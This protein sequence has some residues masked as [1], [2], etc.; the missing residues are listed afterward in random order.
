[1]LLTVSQECSRGAYRDEMPTRLTVGHDVQMLAT[2][3]VTHDSLRCACLECLVLGCGDLGH[4]ALG[5]AYLT[6]HWAKKQSRHDHHMPCLL[7][8]LAQHLG[9]LICLTM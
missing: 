3:F 9:P 8:R 5:N 1:M 2:K 7:K 6:L 4:R